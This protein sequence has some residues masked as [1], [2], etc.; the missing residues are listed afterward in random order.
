MCRNIDGSA[1]AWLAKRGGNAFTGRTGARWIARPGDPSQFIVAKHF[2]WLWQERSKIEKGF[3]GRFLVDGNCAKNSPFMTQQIVQKDT[4]ATLISAIFNLVEAS[5]Q[6]K[7]YKLD[8]KSGK[9]Y[10]TVDA[11]LDELRINDTPMSYGKAVQVLRNVAATQET[12][13]FDHKEYHE[14]DC[15]MLLTFASKLGKNTPNLR[16]IVE[17]QKETGE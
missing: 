15:K 9:V 7:N 17:N 13:V 8:G 10:V 11:L 1:A 3:V 6:R 14:V 12:R 5:S 2:L 4:T 16:K